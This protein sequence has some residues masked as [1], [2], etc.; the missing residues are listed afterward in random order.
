M[1]EVVVKARAL[2]LG[3][4][5][6]CLGASAWAGCKTDCRNDYEDE[7]ESCRVLHYEADDADDLILCIENARGD[8]EDCLQACED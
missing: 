8:V 4:V 5:L 1:L 7:V 6:I 3:L 2:A